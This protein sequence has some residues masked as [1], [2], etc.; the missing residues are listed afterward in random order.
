MTGAVLEA[1]GITKRFPGVTALD[2]V[3]FAARAGEVHALMGENGAGKSTLIKVLTGVHPRDAGEVRVAGRPIHP[4][5]PR[6]AEAAGIATVYQEVNLIPDLSVAENI[7]LGRQPGWAGLVAW[8]GVRRRARAAL[9]RLGLELEVDRTLSACSIAVQQLVAVARALDVSARVL[10][11]DEPTSS[12]DEREV[13]EL[14][15]VIRRLRA[16]GMAVIFVTHFLDQVYE[17]SDRITVLRNG[18]LVGEFP[19]AELPRLQLVSH[20]LGRPAGEIAAGARAAAAPAPGAEAPLL[21]VRGFGRR[22]VLQPVDLQVRAG[23]VLGLAG[24]LGSGRTELA[25]L[26]FGVA[27]ADCGEMRID[28]RSAEARSPAAS[29]RRRFGFTPEDRKTQAIL[30]NLTVRENLIVALQ[31]RRGLWRRIPRG[32]QDRLTARF[33]QALG[34]KTSGPEQ[35]IRNLSGGNQQKVILAR[36]LATEPRLLI[37]DEPTRGIDVGA[38]ADLERL[39]AQLR[40]EGLALIFISSE[41]AELARNSQRVIVLR[42]R[43]KVA[44]LAGAQISEEAVMHAIAEQT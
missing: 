15:T 20:M 18:R 43:A 40:A 41:I 10:I 14:F 23:E 11:L 21:E 28:G 17:I 6:E 39:L 9:A 19:A 5:S 4:R 30:P 27:R 29:L 38:Q 1:S 31:V 8:G 37:L 33:V 25:E 36:W 34:I 12:L 16:E 22:G 26:L 2:G 7:C 24:L 13:K 35:A 42:D 32:E 44:E 3:A